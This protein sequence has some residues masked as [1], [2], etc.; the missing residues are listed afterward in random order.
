[1]TKSAGLNGFP[2]AFLIHFNNLTARSEDSENPNPYFTSFVLFMQLLAS[3][4]MAAIREV[5]LNYKGAFLNKLA[6][7]VGFKVRNLGMSDV[8]HRLASYSTL[9]RSIPHATDAGLLTEFDLGSG[10]LGGIDK[11][12]K[13]AQAL[14]NDPDMVVLSSDLEKAYNSVLRS[15]TWEAIKEIDFPPLTQW[16]IYA[17]GNSPVV[18]YVIDGRLPISPNNVKKILLKIGLPQGDSLS[19]FLFSITLRYVLRKYFLTIFH[20]NLLK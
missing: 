14:A 16:F 7:N 6:P 3:G 4:K 15:D 19:G 1:V 9:T 18:N 12:V 11:F 10:R 20:H 5:A 17:Y 8:F 2:P 13:I